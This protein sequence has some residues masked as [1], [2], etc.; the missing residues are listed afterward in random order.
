MK[1]FFKQ[2]GS[3]FGAGIAAA[4]CLGV[5]LVLSTLGAVGLG[6][7]V[8]D[9]YLVPLFVGFVGLSLWTLYCSARK[10]ARTQPFWLALTG[11]LI[12][13]VGL[14]L[15][16]TG[17]YPR[18]WP[19]FAGL[20]LLVSSSVWDLVNGRRKASCETTC[21]PESSKAPDSKRRAVI[22]AA[23]SV[24]AAGAFYGL[25]KSVEVMTPK[26]EEGD[27]A[28]WGINACKGTTACTTAFNACT[29]QNACKGLGYLNVPAQ[30]C[31]AR[32]G[33]PLEG[34]PGDPARG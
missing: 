26:A 19:V 17:Q 8:H 13:S 1:D 7:I 29:T 9:A 25:Y 34:S 16:V 23:L 10:H 3:L 21:A 22:S 5:P 33:Q 15:L 11:G 20:A 30:E 2:V 12:S 27:I 32:G 28:C 6:F 14:W 31:K 24:A 18:T 4:C